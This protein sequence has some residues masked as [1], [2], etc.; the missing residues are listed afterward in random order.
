MRPGDGG[1]LLVV[2]PHATRTGST[3][4]LCD[5]LAGLGP[6]LGTPLAVRVLSGGPRLH[7]LRGHGSDLR[8]GEVPRAVL[9]NGSLAAHVLTA[10]AADVPSAVYVHEAGEVLDGLPGPA[11]RGLAVADRLWCVSEE[12]EAALRA[13]G[14]EPSRTTVLPP[15]VSPASDPGPEARAAARRAMGVR[16]GQRLVLGCGEASARKGTDLFLEVAARLADD[17][18]HLAWVGRR[19]RA[20][21]RRLDLDGAR[22]G[23]DGR[24]TWVGEVPSPAAHLAAAD[25]LVL[26]SRHDPQPLVPVE[27]AL[28]GTPAAAFAVGGLRDLGGAGAVRCAPFPDVP[29]LTRHVRDLLADG[30]VA[31]A[32]VDRA[33]RWWAERQAPEAVLPAVQRELGILLGGAR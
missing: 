3:Q 33:R 24:V 9:V 16:D 2:A 12:V 15:V 21:A 7:E 5:L 28:V 18:V 32:T 13:Q 6:G 4:V 1:R 20:F 11:R 22:T 23:L 17:D 19:L 27:A 8:P 25:V 26:P 10:F 31:S 30:E 14:V 29:A